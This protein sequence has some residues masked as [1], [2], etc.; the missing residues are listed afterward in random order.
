MN[1]NAFQTIFDK[2]NDNPNK[3]W[4]K[5]CGESYNKAIK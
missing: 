5:K 2:S 3:I 1:T 4:V